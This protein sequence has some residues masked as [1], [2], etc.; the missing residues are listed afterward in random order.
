MFVLTNIFNTPDNKS[1]GPIPDILSNEF[2]AWY[3]PADWVSTH[4]AI[5]YEYENKKK[6]W[7]RIIFYPRSYEQAKDIEQRN[8]KARSND[9]WIRGFIKSNYRQVDVWAVFVDKKFASEKEDAGDVIIF[10]PDYPCI[11]QL[12]KWEAN[13]WKLVKSEKFTKKGDVFKLFPAMKY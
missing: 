9:L 1:V 10:T 5:Q 13:K 7:A 12:Y 4:G 2:S 6:G 3:G 11:A 8:K